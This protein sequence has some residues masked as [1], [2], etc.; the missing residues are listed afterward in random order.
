MCYVK[1][2]IKFQRSD[3][4]YERT[5]S[6]VRYKFKEYLIPSIFTSLAIS[7][8][9]V[10]DSAIVGNLLG[11]KALAAVGLSSPIIFCINLL[12]L[13]FATGGLTCA[14]IE[15]GKFNS[16]KANK[17]FTIT[18]FAGIVISLLFAIVMQLTMEPVC[19]LLASGD[20]ETAK[21]ISQYLR[22]LVFV[23]IFIMLASGMAMF[24]KA[25]GKPRMS[26]AIVLLANFVNL[27]LDYVL[28]K[29]FNT[30]I[31]GAGLSTVLGYVVGSIVI[32]PYI[33]SS[34]RL[35]KFVKIGK[36]IGKLFLDI[37][38]TGL[39]K[40]LIQLTSLGRSIILN[41]I[42]MMVAGPIGMAIMTVC[43]NVNMISN[44]FIGGT[45]DAL[46]PIVG[47]LYGDRDYFGVKK[48]IKAATVVLSFAC[49]SLL[50]FFELMPELIGRWFGITATNGVDLL[51]PA[52]RLYSLY[53]PFY[54]INMLL[55]NF[56]ATTGRRNIASVISILDGFVFV[57]GF[58]FVFAELKE[59]LLW[60]C[61][62][63]SGALT[64][65]CILIIGIIVRKKEKVTG[66][67]LLKEE[68]ENAI[69]KE[70]SLK[71]TKE[72]VVNISKKVIDFCREQ[73]IDN[74]T[75]N[76][77]G[78]AIEEMAINVCRFG[79][80]K[81]SR[82]DILIRISNEEIRVR[83]R[84]NG[85]AFNPLEYIVEDDRCITDGIIIAKKLA[86]SVDY[87]R[88]LGFNM[89]ILVFDR[90]KMLIN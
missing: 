36:D 68:K 16:K 64:L 62:S 23:G 60:L 15:I 8:A 35:F 40:G 41:G 54:C 80:N 5:G 12:Y 87:M 37:V 27:V 47:T 13:L 59:N 28:I 10:V 67:L 71:A 49:V 70:M 21:L 25:D 38:K 77:I 2:K 45:S 3:L 34:K 1:I 83:L 76:R 4:M 50:L 39:P 85:D 81:T 19:S 86:S 52:I 32:I 20:I 24:I 44:I 79:K 46:I 72:D 51:V 82:I 7:L 63:C 61:F 43:Q 26:A 56:Y 90:N 6:L 73:N 17:Y 75:S 58:A 18:I 29:Y 88:Q 84:D 53:L 14:S 11:D 48:A 65:I 74:M 57:C 31:M 89:T 55:Q 78:V 22:P 33:L 30:G 42:I 66:I 9:S 69:A